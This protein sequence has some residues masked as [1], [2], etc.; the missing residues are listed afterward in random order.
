[1][2]RGETF[3]RCIE[4]L[5]AGRLKQHRTLRFH[6]FPGRV[7][8][9]VAQLVGQTLPAMSNRPNGEVPDE[10]DRTTPEP[11]NAQEM[12]DRDSSLR[13]EI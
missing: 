3:G 1:M 8:A 11:S 5:G 9:L 7:L 12:N 10:K 13:A 6:A 2:V 4:A